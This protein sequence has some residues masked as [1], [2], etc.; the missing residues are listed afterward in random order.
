MREY[1]V[2]QFIE[3]EAKITFFLTFRQFIFL[4]LLAI[5]GYIFYKIF[6]LNLFVL[7]F[8]P[9]A[10]VVLAFAFVNIEGQPLTVLFKNYLYFLRGGKQYVWKKKKE[11]FPKKVIVPKK[12]E[13]EKDRPELKIGGE[14]KLKNLKIE[15]ETKQLK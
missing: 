9:I 15:I 11:V 3:K 6:P 4:F 7:V 13:I 8:I 1:P 10:L 2:P 5:I 14:S 12:I